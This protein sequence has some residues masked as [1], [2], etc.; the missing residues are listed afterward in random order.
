VND[1]PTVP[2]AGESLH[3]GINI[4]DLSTPDHVRVSRVTREVPSSVVELYDQRLMW[5]SPDGEWLAY[6]R[7]QGLSNDIIVC[8][9]DGSDR[10]NASEL[11]RAAGR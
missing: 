10:F 8:R 2:A 6:S 5:W 11:C 7:W 1:D 9:A 4:V 3:R